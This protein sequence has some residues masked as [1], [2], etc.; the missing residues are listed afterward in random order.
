M[1]SKTPLTAS[2][3]WWINALFAYHAGIIGVESIDGAI[4]FDQH[5]AYAVVLD[6]S[7]EIEASSETHITYR[8]GLMDRGRYRLTAANFRSR[9]P[10]RVLRS[11]SLNSI[12]GPKAGVRYE[13]LYKVISWV[14]RPAKPQDVSGQHE[15]KL[16]D[17]IYEVTFERIDKKPM[18][19]V[20]K[21]PTAGELDDYT[22][23]KR[24]R[25]VDREDIRR[26]LAPVG[27]LQFPRR[28]APAI[29]PAP[30]SASSPPR[31]SNGSSPSS[32]KV[33]PVAT[34]QDYF[35]GVEKTQ[36]EIPTQELEVTASSISKSAVPSRSDLSTKISYSSPLAGSSTHRGGS[37]DSRNNDIR[38]IAPWEDHVVE[39]AAI[40]SSITA[41]SGLQDPS[42]AFGK[43]SVKSEGSNTHASS[44]PTSQGSS[45]K[46]RGTLNVSLANLKKDGRELMKAS[47]RKHSPLTKLYDGTKDSATYQS[48]GNSSSMILQRRLRASSSS[49]L[50]EQPFIPAL[51]D[52]FV[53]P[54]KPP[55]SRHPCYSPRS[56]TSLISSATTAAPISVTPGVSPVMAD[57]PRLSIGAAAEQ[58][59]SSLQTTLSGGLRRL[60]ERTAPQLSV[61]L[62]VFRNPFDAVEER[63]LRDHRQSSEDA[64]QIAP[65]MSATD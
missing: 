54:P 65:E 37:G 27:H 16:G 18:E 10:I 35:S 61:G 25:R 55:Q 42:L 17:L 9:S 56:L 44:N 64:E 32:V 53:N 52:P 21:H 4:T 13:G 59:S 45:L 1:I 2:S 57:R 46:K 39:R 5:G 28:V 49:D 38:E 60:A 47:S 43:S 63:G 51:E 11:H 29:A 12:W 24:L 26:A 36:L 3:S 19:Y 6:D 40:A 22:E 41:R 20:L 34:P 23:Y 14:V 8:C 31:S 15:T 62:I 50:A 30:L 58:G 7:S 48:E 33:A